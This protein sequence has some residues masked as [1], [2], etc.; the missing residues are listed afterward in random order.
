M[1]KVGQKELRTG[2][3][4]FSLYSPLP[5]LN[6]WEI[7]VLLLRYC[8]RLNE[9]QVAEALL[10]E[11]VSSGTKMNIRRLVSQG[12]LKLYRATLPAQT[13]P[14]LMELQKCIKLDLNM[15][16]TCPTVEE[17]EHWMKLLEKYGLKVEDLGL[18]RDAI[19]QNIASYKPKRSVSFPTAIGGKVYPRLHKGT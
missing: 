2:L 14:L 16:K 19:L 12:K 18:Q 1:T 17:V 8:L 3:P 5:D 4:S 9:T 13:D 10:E 11:G 15:D 7:L 6:E